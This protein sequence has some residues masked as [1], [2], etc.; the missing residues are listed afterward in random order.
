[1]QGDEDAARVIGLGADPARVHVAGN[2]KFEHVSGAPPDGVR[3]LGT[4][5]AGRPM[6][7]AGSTHEGEE[8]ALL[9][10]YARA[11]RTTPA[12]RPAARAATSR[13]PRRRRAAGGRPR[14]AARR[15]TGP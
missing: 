2:L 8:A 10:A 7:V 5:L 6:L 4:L 14:A 3:V 15:A 12:A 13:A 9:D 1:M 11:R